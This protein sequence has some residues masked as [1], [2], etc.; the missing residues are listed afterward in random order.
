MGKA[1]GAEEMFTSKSFTIMK[2]NSENDSY[3]NL[4]NY[5]FKLYSIFSNSA[6]F[7]KLCSS[8][9]NRALFF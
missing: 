4:H 9:H 5:L 1:N 2:Q 3:K 8:F 7:S 6:L